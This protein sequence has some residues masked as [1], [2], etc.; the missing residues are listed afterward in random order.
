MKAYT[1]PEYLMYTSGSQTERWTKAKEA[2]KA[3]LNRASFAYKLDLTKPESA[4]EGTANYMALSLAGGSKM[5][6]A[7]GAKDII[8]GRFFI[9][10]K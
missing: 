1:K 10:E 8:L 4:T 3:V 7:A 6:D 5:A 2:A 9:N